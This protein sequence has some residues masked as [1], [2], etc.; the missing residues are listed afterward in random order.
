MYG[1]FFASTGDNPSTV[2][3]TRCDN[4]VA[5]RTNNHKFINNFETSST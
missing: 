4:K 2:V 1:N 5:I 3:S